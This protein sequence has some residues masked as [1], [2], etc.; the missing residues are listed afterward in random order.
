MTGS[1]IILA[2]AVVRAFGEVMDVPDARLNAVLAKLKDTLD[3]A[4][5][6]RPTPTP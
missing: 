5:G 6:I 1:D 4:R 3:K 2:E